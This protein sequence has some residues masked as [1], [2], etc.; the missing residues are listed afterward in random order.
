MQSVLKAS[1][2]SRK[3]RRS[4]DNENDEL[5]RGSG[6]GKKKDIENIKI[7]DSPVADNKVV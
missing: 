5:P 7:S 1:P 6:V 3:L 4:E 2:P